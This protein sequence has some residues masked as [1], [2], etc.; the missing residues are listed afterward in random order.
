MSEQ[1]PWKTLS[2]KLIYQNPWIKVRED[3]VIAPDGSNSIYSVVE[4]KIAVGVL[5]INEVNE[6][7]M[8]GQYRYPINQYSWEIIEGGAELGED[9]LDCAKR[10]LKEEAGLIANKWQPLSK[11]I[12]LSNCFTSEVG[13]L[14]LAQNLE[15]GNNCPDSTEVLQLKKIP[16]E[17][18]LRLIDLGEIS[19]ALTIMAIHLYKNNLIN[20]L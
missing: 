20:K 6:V 13:Y 12:H 14:F 16:F 15:I 5:A 11:K 18:V 1:N 19:D 3:A 17:E 9:P 8:V 7:Y 10:E 2:T 4:P